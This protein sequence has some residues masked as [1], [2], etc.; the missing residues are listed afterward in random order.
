MVRLLQF[1]IGNETDNNWYKRYYIKLHIKCALNWND[2]TIL[3][4]I[5]VENKWVEENVQYVKKCDLGA[6]ERWCISGP[7]DLLQFLGSRLILFWSN[8]GSRMV[9]HFVYE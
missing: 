6:P 3:I 8:E 9:V 7:G 2:E 1:E 5:C 4:Q